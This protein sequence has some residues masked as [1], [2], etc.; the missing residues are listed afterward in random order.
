[1]HLISE[2]NTPFSFF[3]LLFISY[4]IVG[5]TLASAAVIGGSGTVLDMLLGIVEVLPFGEFFLRIT[6]QILSTLMQTTSISVDSILNG[7]VSSGSL[8]AVDWVKE[9]CKLILAA[10]FNDALY[11]FLVM[12]LNL[13]RSD[14]WIF[15]KR[16]VVMMLSAYLAAF[17]AAMSLA[18][19]FNQLK[20]WAA[21]WQALISGLIAAISVGGVFAIMCILFLDGGSIVSFII[22]F[23]L[24]YVLLGIMRVGIAYIGALSILL[25]V[26]SGNLAKL[27]AGQGALLLVL[28]MLVGVDMLLGSAFGFGD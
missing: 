15:M 26:Q 10:G 11:A 22:Y 12:V 21:G 25:L 5:I 16:V 4:F 27:I 19:V 3:A 20:G 28:I 13:S 7:T 8:L 18:A 17:A 14:F 1:M 24:R 23:L 9:T 2:E 6:A